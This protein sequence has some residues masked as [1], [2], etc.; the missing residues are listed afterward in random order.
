MDACLLVVGRQLAGIEQQ[1]R[2]DSCRLKNA[3]IPARG[4]VEIRNRAAT[5]RYSPPGGL[6]TSESESESQA[7]AEAPW[8]QPWR[9]LAGW[10]VCTLAG[11]GELC[12]YTATDLTCICAP[13]RRHSA[14]VAL[15]AATGIIA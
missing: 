6:L 1:Q 11:L 5:D 3:A 13:A 14:S 12:Y 15:A 2:L 9:L 4:R 7:E 10:P 8:L